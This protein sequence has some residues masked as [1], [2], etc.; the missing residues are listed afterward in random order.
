MNNIQ[1]VYPDAPISADSQEIRLFVLLPGIINSQV[2]GRLIRHSLQDESINQPYDA[3]SYMWGP[4]ANPKK[5]QLNQNNSFA[6]TAA[7]ETALQALRLPNQARKIW[8]DAICINQGD[9]QER[10]QQVQLMR[11]IY[12]NAITVRIWLDVDIDPESSTM[13]RLRILNDQSTEKDL[14]D[15]PSFWEPLCAVFKN[16]YWM[17]IWIQQEI[18]NAK[19][20]AIQ[21]RRILMPVYNLYHYIRIMTDRTE[22]ADINTPI[23][24]DW[25]DVRPNLLLPKRFG[26][27]DSSSQPIQGSTLSVQELSLLVTLSSCFKLECSDDRDRVYGVLYLAFDYSEGDIP[28]SYERSIQ[29]VYASVAEF[30]LRKYNSLNFMLYAGINWRDPSSERTLPTWVP[31]WRDPSTRT[32]LSHSPKLSQ[33]PPLITPRLKSTISPDGT[34]LCA[35]GI[36]IDRIEHAFYL[37]EGVEMYITPTTTFL[38]ICRTIV[39]AAS[40]TQHDAEN[41]EHDRDVFC[42]PQWYSLV[43]VLAGVDLL[44]PEDPD[45]NDILRRGVSQSADNLIKASQASEARARERPPLTMVDI[46]RPN[47]STESESGQMF[48]R[49]A[50]GVIGKHQPWVGAKGGIGM[51]LKSAKAG[52]EVWMMLGCEQPMILRSVGDYYLVIGEGSFDELN[53]GELLKDLSKN[54][55]IGDAI[56]SYRVESIS[57]R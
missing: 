35:Y 53:R 38:G 12:R 16:P 41:E 29:E 43:R 8:I 49:L 55:N 39:N 40:L 18:S 6:I 47:T 26:E 31:D 37:P 36:C 27:I 19:A 23:W 57:L 14:G 2:S 56:G 10:N 45:A 1:N 32:W 21:C 15:R 9:V 24:I 48:A 50:W 20:L 34:A 13:I 22:A 52:D 30:M 3:L 44:K 25:L 51:S 11:R 7:L 54:V 4:I 17:R 33:E 5:I 46:I 28:I 42:L